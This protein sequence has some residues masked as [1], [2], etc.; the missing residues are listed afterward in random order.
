MQSDMIGRWLNVLLLNSEAATRGVLQKKAIYRKGTVL[1]SLFNKVAGL[2]PCN[3][4]KKRLQ[5]MCFPVNIAK[6]LR[7]PILRN[8]CKQTVASINFKINYNM[9]ITRFLNICKRNLWR[10]MLR[11]NFRNLV[12]C[13]DKKIF[14]KNFLLTLFYC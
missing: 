8:I 2:Q 11:N 10:K 4:I 14:V 6:F 9:I 7:T 12:F 3:F 1:E 5:H 13:S